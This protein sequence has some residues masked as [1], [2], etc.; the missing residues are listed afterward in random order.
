MAV[1]S[2][3]KVLR[4]RQQTLE[5]WLW[6][7]GQQRKSCFEKRLS[8]PI[9]DQGLDDNAEVLP[10]VHVAPF[11][12]GIPSHAYNVPEYTSVANGIVCITSELCS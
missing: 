4:E 6:S 8:W 1:A 10:Q 5:P 3:T 12:I 7:F 11:C 2:P 9:D